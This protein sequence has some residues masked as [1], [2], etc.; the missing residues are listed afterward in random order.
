MHKMPLLEGL[1]EAQCKAVMHGEGPALVAAGPGSGKTLTIVRRI[2]YLIYEMGIAAD[3]ILVITYTREAAL[4]M[5]QKYCQQL[6]IVDFSQSLS[7]NNV[8][9]GT[10]HSYFYQIIRNNIKYSEY[11]L[12][13]Q[14][15]KKKIVCD[16]LKSAGEAPTDFAVK[17]FLDQVSFYKNTGRAKESSEY[18]KYYQRYIEIM[19]IFKRL[20]FDDMLYLCKQEFL[21]NDNL[22]IS[23]RKQYD[24]ILIDEFQDINPIQYEL[25]FLLTC[26]YRNLFVVGDD[27]QAIYGFRGTDVECFH[28][29]QQDFPDA[30]LYYLTTNYRCG[31]NIVNASKRLISHNKNRMPKNIMSDIKGRGC[32]RICVRESMHV[33][34]SYEK[35][36]KHLKT[37]DITHLN[38]EA[39]LFRTNASMQSFATN[40]LNEGIPFVLREKIRS[41]YE[42]FIVSDI[43]DYFDAAHGCKER[44]LYLR[45][46]QKYHMDLE[47]EVLREDKVDLNEVKRLFAQGFYENKKAL[48]YIEKL[49]RQLLQLQKMRLGL[50]IRYILHG[51]NYEE[52]LLRKAGNKGRLPEEWQEVLEWIQKDAERYCEYADW[53]ESKERSI[54]DMQGIKILNTDRQGIHLMTMHA[55]KGL[56]FDKVYIMHLNEGV[57]PKYKRGELLTKEAVEEERRLFY[58]ALTRAKEEIELHYISGTKENPRMQSRFLEEMEIF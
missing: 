9:F 46:F 39:I 18:T 43:S 53:L 29:F 45:I 2:L 48:Y 34:E 8:S 16:I 7:Q 24:Y 37:I 22:L 33:S 23:C 1:S 56:E 27:D 50:G 17:K 28:K 44:S 49:E 13:T 38:R 3:K 12:I 57:I 35:L 58:V 32:G 54:N 40:L 55:S 25:I 15:E 11:Q 4:S 30:K 31:E 47:R 6:R 42:H 21:E 41:V 19:R 52:Y 51:M 26:K 14:K 36:M 5:Q 10:F 20:D